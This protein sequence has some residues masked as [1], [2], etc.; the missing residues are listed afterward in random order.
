MNKKIYRIVEE[1]AIRKYI[2]NR[3]R[4]RKEYMNSIL[5]HINDNELDWVVGGSHEC[6]N[7]IS[8]K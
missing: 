4:S 6:S 5:R 7:I 2:K 8:V 3:E 1:N